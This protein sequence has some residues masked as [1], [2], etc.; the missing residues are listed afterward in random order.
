MI[1]S[2]MKTRTLA[3]A[4][5]GPISDSRAVE[6]LSAADAAGVTLIDTADVYEA[7]QSESR[8]GAF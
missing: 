6:S 8:I 4:D 1:E 5:W 3:G 2:P 7:G